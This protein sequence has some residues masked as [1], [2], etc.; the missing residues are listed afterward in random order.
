MEDLAQELGKIT[1]KEVKKGIVVSGLAVVLG[2]GGLVTYFKAEDAIV[3]KIFCDNYRGLKGQPA[4]VI[5]REGKEYWGPKTN[6]R[7]LN[8]FVQWVDQC[9]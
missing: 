8:Y 2:F 1:W 4:E 6:E 7:N 5:K 3:E 9:K